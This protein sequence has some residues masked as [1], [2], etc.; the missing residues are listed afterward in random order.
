MLL[1]KKYAIVIIINSLHKNSRIANLITEFK[2]VDLYTSQS[3]R[4]VSLNI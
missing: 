1:C 3:H 4:L 2:I